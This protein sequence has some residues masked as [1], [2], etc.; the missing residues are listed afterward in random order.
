MAKSKWKFNFIDSSLYKQIFLSKLKNLRT[1]RLFCRS[2]VV[3]KIFLKKTINLYK[4]NI[5]TK[6][7]FNKYQLGYKIGEF[8]ITRKPFNFP[9]KNI[10]S[11]R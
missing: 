4:G 10:K 8:N 11:K 5:F 3:P 2:S 7:L 6:I 1:M 9:L